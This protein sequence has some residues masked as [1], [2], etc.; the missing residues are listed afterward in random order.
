MRVDHVGGG[1]GGRRGATAAVDQA[2]QDPT[3][4]MRRAFKYT[5]A[6]NK[7]T[8]EVDAAVYVLPSQ[9]IVLK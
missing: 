4:W 7:G 8:D 5:R 6:L 1:E 2:F 9:S 3:L